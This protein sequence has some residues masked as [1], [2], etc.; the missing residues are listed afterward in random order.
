MYHA[1]QVPFAMYAAYFLIVLLSEALQLAGM[2][3]TSHTWIYAAGRVYVTIEKLVC[4]VMLSPA[5]R[6]NV[7]LLHR[8]RG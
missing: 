2:S 3:W 5:V 4:A 8:M 6:W 1:D 7:A